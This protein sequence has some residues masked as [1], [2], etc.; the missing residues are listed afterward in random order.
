MLG[1]V[2]Y[3]VCIST[4]SVEG[5]AFC[6]YMKQIWLVCCDQSFALLHFSIISFLP[7]SNCNNTPIRIPRLKSQI[8]MK[9]WVQIEIIYQAQE[10]QTLNAICV[11]PEEPVIFPFPE[12][13]NIQLQLVQSSSRRKL[14]RTN[15]SSYLNDSSHVSA[16]SKISLAG[17]VS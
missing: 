4:V 3:M 13:L 15:R 1:S 6:A 11:L 17:T 7:Y 2:T 12:S 10:V 8:D 16:H 14:I 9:C 5:L